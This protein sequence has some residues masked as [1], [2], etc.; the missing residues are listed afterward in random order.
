MAVIKINDLKV[1]T[2]IGTNPQE[3]RSKQEIILN[4]TFEYDAAKASQS[5][6]L[7][8]ALDYQ[9]LSQDVI[10]YIQES[11]FAL[12]ETLSDRVLKLIMNEKKILAAEVRI[13]KPKALP[14][15]S[16]VSVEMSRKRED[17]TS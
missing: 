16:S 15:A 9:K 13:D 7:K 12:L 5:D 11:H 2:F 10:K 8:H 3:K 14:F 4:I 6:N 1:R 17:Q